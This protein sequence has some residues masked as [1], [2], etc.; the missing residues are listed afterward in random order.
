VSVKKNYRPALA[1]L[2]G[3]SHLQIIWWGHQVDN[4]TDRGQLTVPKPYKNGP[5]TLGIF[6]TRSKIRPN[7]VLVTTVMVSN[8]DHENGLIEIPWID[9]N[10]GSP[11][12][13]I[14]PYQPCSDRVKQVNLPN[15]RQNWPDDYED[16]AHFDWGSVFNF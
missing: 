5:N 4:S 16:S 8:I 2:N 12:I 6:A 14:K 11:V 9:A 13:D 3:F 7:P 1:E 15:W 10:I